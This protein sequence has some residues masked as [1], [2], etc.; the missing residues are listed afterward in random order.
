[1]VI[2]YLGAS[3]LNSSSIGRGGVDMAIGG[4]SKSILLNPANLS[5]IA[6]KKINIEYLN[7][8]ISLNRDTLSFIKALGSSNSTQKVSELMNK[9]IG[10]TLNFSANNFVSIYKIQNSY[11]WLLGLYS[12][13]D[14]DFITHTGFGSIGAM[15][16]FVD[17]YSVVVTTLSFNQNSIEYGFNLKAIQKYQTIHNYT[18]SEIIGNNDILNYFDNQ[19]TKNEKAI[20]FDMGALY[21]LSTIPTEPKLALSIL[22]IGD[23]SFNDLGSI[24]STTNIGFS[25]IYKKFLFGIDYM[26]IF[27]AKKDS[28]LQNSLRIG[29]SRSFLDNS[30]TL[31]SGILYQKLSFGI[32]YRYSNFYISLNAYNKEEYQLSIALKW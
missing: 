3:N 14:G 8:S 12:D 15:E 31:S 7:S 20:A 25:N 4:D 29:M 24:S 5:K 17:R 9:N 32:D 16:S 26:D 18:I 11:S 21:Q 30:L 19:Y 13:I 28:S 1:M 10:K 22:D 27:Q 2:I 23:T 6:D